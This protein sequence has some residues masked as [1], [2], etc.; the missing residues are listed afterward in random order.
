MPMTPADLVANHREHYL[1]RKLARSPLLHF[2]LG[3]YRLDVCSLLEGITPNIPTIN[4]VG[5]T[6]PESLI[7]AL[8]GHRG[9]ATLQTLGQRQF[10]NLNAFG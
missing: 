3:A 8:L 6:T 9:E 5:V 2:T 7:K 4:E 1:S 10:K